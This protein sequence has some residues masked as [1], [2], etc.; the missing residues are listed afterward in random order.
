MINELI[1][2]ENVTMFLEYTVRNWT[3]EGIVEQL[4]EFGSQSDSWMELPIPFD[5][6][7][8][9][10]PV[11]INYYFEQKKVISVL[12]PYKGCNQDFI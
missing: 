1:E 4:L 6:F 2:T 7:G 12:H 5:K 10:Y 9:F 8:W 3:F 11:R